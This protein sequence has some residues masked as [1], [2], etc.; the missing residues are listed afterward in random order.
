MRERHDRHKRVL[1][2]FARLSCA[3]RGRISFPPVI[4]HVLHD[5]VQ[6]VI[7]KFVRILVHRAAKELVEL[8]EFVDEGAR[9]DSALVCRV[10]ADVQKERAERGQERWRGGGNGNGGGCIGV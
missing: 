6:Q 10:S 1:T 8:F 9:R 2:V 4:L 3:V 5:L 7:E